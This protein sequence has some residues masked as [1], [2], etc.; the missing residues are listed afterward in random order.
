MTSDR[1]I[2]PFQ[3]ERAAIGRSGYNEPPISTGYEL[4]MT[5]SK[6]WYGEF[7]HCPIVAYSH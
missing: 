2:P 6:G 5:C 1:I 7:G 3:F 4:R